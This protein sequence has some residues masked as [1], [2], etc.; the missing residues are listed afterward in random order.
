ML[1]A[2][3]VATST[4]VGRDP[5]AH[6]QGGRDR[7]TARGRTR[8]RGRD[9]V[10]LPRGLAAPAPYRAGL[11]GLRRC[12]T[13]AAGPSLTSPRSSRFE[14]IAALSGPGSRAARRRGRRPLRPGHRRGAA[15][16]AR[17]GD[18][19]AAP[20][21]AGRAGPGRGGG[22]RRGARP[23]RAA[24]GDARRVDGGGRGRRAARG[25]R[26]ARRVRVARRAPAAADA[27][28]QRHLGRGGGGGRWRVRSPW[29]PSSTASGSRST[30][31]REVT[32]RDADAGGHHR[33]AA[34]GRRRVA[35][36]LPAQAFVLDGEALVLDEAGRPRP[37]QDTASRTAKAAGTVVMTPVLLRRPA[38]R[39]RRPAGLALLASAW[40]PWTG[41]CR[42]SAGAAAGDRR[43]GGG[44]GVRRRAVAAGHEGVVVKDLDSPYAAGRRGRAWVKVK[45]V[46]T[47]DLVVLAVER[48]SGRRAGWLS[49]IHLGAR[50]P[51]TGG[52]SCWARRSRA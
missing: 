4:A 25:R 2:D 7:R 38:P 23:G 17:G 11:A 13:P 26:R 20:G 47:L 6:G 14:G 42:R 35:R 50:D 46:H 32:D 15:L 16:A 31:G 49:N 45:P 10:V 40:R 52:S 39:R 36:D 3:V 48:G 51:G 27:R 19:R 8:R 41:W 22:G 18:G 34:R 37:F 9:R 21:R 1:L 33:P 24:R 29:T 43:S 28:R 30:A 44:R 12:P 5:F